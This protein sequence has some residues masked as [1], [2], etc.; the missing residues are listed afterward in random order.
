MGGVTLAPIM[1]EEVLFSPK[2]MHFCS[3]GCL[4]KYFQIQCI[5]PVEPHERP[6]YNA[7]RFWLVDENANHME[8]VKWETGIVSL[9]NGTY[10]NTWNLFKSVHSESSVQWID[11]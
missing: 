10:Y 2:E 1:H 3:E 9:E 6:N 4:Q 7:R 5:C 11:Q 8:A